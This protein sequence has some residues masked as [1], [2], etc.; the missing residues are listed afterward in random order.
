MLAKSLRCPYTQLLITLRQCFSTPEQ[1]RLSDAMLLLEHEAWGEE[2]MSTLDSQDEEE[3]DDDWGGA[4]HV[5]CSH[6]SEQQSPNLLH[7]APLPLHV[8]PAPPH[9]P[10]LQSAL[11]H[12]PF[13][14]HFFPSA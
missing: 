1:H 9:T 8:A 13:D 14:V 3:E 2:D 5:P 4:M 6:A 7:D 11:Q 10:P 12:C